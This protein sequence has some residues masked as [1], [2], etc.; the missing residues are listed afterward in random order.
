MAAD[1]RKRKKRCSYLDECKDDR[2]IYAKKANI[3]YSENDENNGL[4]ESVSEAMEIDTKPAA[5]YLEESKT[6]VS[7][8]E[9]HSTEMN[10]DKV[11]LSKP[12]WHEK[13][14]LDEYQNDSEDDASLPQTTNEWIN[15]V[16]LQLRSTKTRRLSLA[17]V[18]PTE[19]RHMDE[20]ATSVLLDGSHTAVKMGTG[21]FG[22]GANF[23]VSSLAEGSKHI[24]TS[25]GLSG[26]VADRET[27]C[28]YV[29]PGDAHDCEEFLDHE[30][31][32]RSKKIGPLQGP[33]NEKNLRTLMK[34]LSDI[35]KES[36][37][38]TDEK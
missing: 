36:L 26:K 11:P 5:R 15:E 38:A 6:T 8:S 16:Q 28:V 32:D 14:N 31:S 3:D 10:V 30:L 2:T 19:Y 21:M 1:S 24:L 37:D 18:T 7:E 9:T 4:K 29:W 35:V 25:E 23:G 17:L 13:A 20:L 27:G 33:W 22:P 12:H 34:K